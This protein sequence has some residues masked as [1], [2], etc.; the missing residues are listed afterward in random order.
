MNIAVILAGGSGSRMRNDTPKQFLEIAGKQVI[1]YSIEAFQNC[2]LIDEICVVTRPDYQQAV[3]ELVRR[4]GYT[5]V[6]QILRGGKERYHST[7]SAINAYPDDDTNLLFHDAVRPAITQQAIIDCI[8]ALKQ[9]NAV[10]VATTT[11]DTIFNINADNCITAIPN[12]NTLRNAQTPQCFKRGLIRRAYEMALQDPDFQTTDDCG[13]IIRYIPDEPIFIVEG[14]H[15]NIK[16]TY[17][18]DLIL[19]KHILASGQ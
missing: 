5:K 7:L 9:Y 16:L 13:T 15:T 8:N 19:I 17:P 12:R 14:G 11:T 6:K 10:C 4:N 2:P 1:Q 3:E 18:E